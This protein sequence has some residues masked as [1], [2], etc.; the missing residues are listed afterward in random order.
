MNGASERRQFYLLADR[1]ITEDGSDQN[2]AAGT[3]KSIHIEAQ[4]EDEMLQQVY[5][6]FSA[7]EYSH[8]VT[9]NLKEI[10]GFI[11]GNAS[12]LGE[13]AQSGQRQGSAH[14]RLRKRRMRADQRWWR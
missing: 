6:E 1:T 12:T 7:N 3:V 13:S 2:R 10:A 5:N 9:F 4:T 8:K 11:P 14:P